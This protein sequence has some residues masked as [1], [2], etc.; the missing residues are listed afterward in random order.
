MPG[1]FA[2]ARELNAEA[3]FGSADPISITNRATIIRLAESAAVRRLST[4]S[5]SRWPTVASF[6]YG[7]DMEGQY[8]SAAIYVDKVL[9]GEKAGD[10]P[11]EQATKLALA[12]NRR[13]AKTLDLDIPPLLLTQAD[14]VI[15]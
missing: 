6:S 11:V 14:D 7:P 8:R 3:L 4:T 1:A 10:L 13:T 15:E 12:V 5:G 2:K 9:R